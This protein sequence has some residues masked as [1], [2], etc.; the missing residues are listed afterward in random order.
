MIDREDRAVFTQ[1]LQQRRRGRRRLASEK[2]WTSVHLD[3]DVFAALCSRAR[4]GR[5][6]LHAFLCDALASQIQ[7]R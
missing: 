1:E 7:T 3:V 6:S 2:V 4:L 5:K